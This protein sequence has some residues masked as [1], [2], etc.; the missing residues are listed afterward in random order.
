MITIDEEFQSIIPPLS[1]EEKQQL[2]ANIVADGCRDPLVLWGNVLVD[3]HNRYEICTRLGIKFKTVQMD[4]ADRD[5]AIDW[6]GVNQ[7]GRRNLTADQRSLLRGRLYNRTKKTMAAAGAMKGK[8]NAEVAQA[9]Q[10]TAEALAK[11]YGVSERTIKSDGKK[12]EAIETLQ[13]ANPEAAE[14]VLKGKKRFNE[15]RREIKL[16]QVKEAAKLPDAKYRVIY[17]DPPWKYGNDMG[18]AMPGTTG[19]RDH[20]PCMTI[21]ELCALPVRELC[22]SDA[23]LFLWVTSPLLYEAAPLIKAWG[24][25]YKTSFVWDK[26]KHNMGHYNSMRHEFLLIC[27]RGSCLPDEKKLFDSVQSIERSGKHSEKP[28]EFRTI[29]DTLYPYGKR[30]ELFRRGG[31]PKG[32]SVWGNQSA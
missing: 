8:A 2:E 19:A 29:I 23:V 14:A 26:I 21:A 16:E 15:V 4:F 9:P 6:I 18:A 12:A 3:G 22:E 24:F 7:L 11:K 5:A 17:A 27:T 1:A 30:I 20:Y 25:E 28:E 32:W 13:E 10:N 31:A